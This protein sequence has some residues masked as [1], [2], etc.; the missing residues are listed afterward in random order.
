VSER[1]DILED[2]RGGTGRRGGHVTASDAA[3]V[4]PVGEYGNLAQARDDIERRVLRGEGPEA[5]RPMR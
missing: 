3:E 1:L 4:S 5:L 2:A